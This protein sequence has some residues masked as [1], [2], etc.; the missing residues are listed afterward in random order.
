ML[1]EDKAFQETAD[2]QVLFLQGPLSP[3]Y[4]LLGRQLKQAGCRVYRINLC[5]GD[6]LHWNGSDARSFK[7]KPQDWP[8]YVSGVMD[9][10]GIT[11]LVLHADQRIYHKM[12]IAEAN[13]RG[14]RVFVTELGLLRSGWMTLE[15]EGLATLSR[16][17]ADPA[18]VRGISRSAGEVDFTPMYP[19]STALEIIP[20]VIY[21]LTNVFLKPLYPSYQRHTLYPPILE[22]L[23]GGWRLFREGARNR[24]VEVQL[25]ELLLQDQPYFIFPLQLEGDFQLRAHSP[26]KSFS[27]VIDTILVSFAE[28][29]PKAAWLVL[30]SH[31]LD[32]GF[33][34]WPIVVR[35][36]AQEY[37][38][39]DRI[40]FLDGGRLDHLF[41]KTSGLVTLNSTAGL[42]AMQCG[43]PVKTLVPAHYDIAGMTHSGDLATFWKR[44]EK[45]D[46]SLVR[47]Y[48]K[49]IAA[50]VQVRGSIH[51]S[52]GID[53]AAQNMAK[54]ILEFSV[55]EPG[56]FCDQPP[57]LAKARALGVPL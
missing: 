49:A 10:L 36:L 44:P 51:N 21:N 53:A 47:D 33:E 38:I 12:A 18:A 39:S 52:E 16:F 20:D 5:A 46:E 19:K 56:G 55:N 22:Y 34:N 30:K 6:W 48:L 14:V 32:A 31:P 35:K 23:R 9:E 40:I 17:P 7:G 1:G 50:T 54:R 45:P 15:R 2:R 13:A 41:S 28:H 57:R 25:D 37:R 3:L 43:V 24:K 11:D 27:E 4:R 8:A 42:E 26:Y 29:A